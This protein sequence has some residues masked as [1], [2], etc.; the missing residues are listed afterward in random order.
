M[1]RDKILLNHIYISENQNWLTSRMFGQK[2][3]MYNI[4]SKVRPS[5]WTEKREIEAY[6]PFNSI[7][8]YIH[9]L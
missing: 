4:S 8:E 3:V 7:K 5:L 2:R 9:V 1:I 6:L